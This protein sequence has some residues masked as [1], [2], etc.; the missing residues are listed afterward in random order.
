MEL[1]DL[2]KPELLAKIALV[3]VAVNALLS[4]LSM[5]LEKL[6]PITQTPKDDQI[7]ALLQKWLPKLKSVV[8]FVSANREHK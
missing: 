3:V 2:V 4:A 1:L 6:A 8:D 7:L 5:I